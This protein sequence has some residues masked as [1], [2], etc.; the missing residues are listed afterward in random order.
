MS[1]ERVKLASC[2]LGSKMGCSSRTCDAGFFH[3]VPIQ[4]LLGSRDK[5]RGNTECLVFLSRPGLAASKSL[6]KHGGGALFTARAA[7]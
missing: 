7:A 4:H 5:G 3:V 1:V 6:T 2:T